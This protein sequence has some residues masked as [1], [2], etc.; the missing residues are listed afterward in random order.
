RGFAGKWTHYDESLRVPLIVHDPRLPEPK[1]G[2]VLPEMALN[3][4]LGATIIDLAGLPA[5]VSHTGRSLLPLLRGEPPGDW[6]REF[7]CEFLAVPRTIPRWEGVRG[8][9]W[10][11]AR[12]FVDGPDKPPFEFLHDLKNDPAQLANVAL[13]EKNASALK[14]MRARCDKLIASHGSPMQKIG[15]S[16]RSKKKKETGHRSSS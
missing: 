8:T 14:R 7:L 12:Y 9:H 1:R 2:R 5:P 4:D 16:T 13:N 3:S 11:Y 10:S 6:R 15:Q